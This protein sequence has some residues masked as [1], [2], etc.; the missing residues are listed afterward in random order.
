MARA[1]RNAV[2]GLALGW[3]AVCSH[4]GSRAAGLGAGW[5]GGRLVCCI[6]WI[7]GF[8]ACD[9]VCSC[10]SAQHQRAR[11]STGTTLWLGIG[12]VGAVYCHVGCSTAL[13]SGP[14]LVGIAGRDG[15]CHE[16]VWVGLARRARPYSLI[17]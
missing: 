6:W 9:R 3:P 16:D 2:V 17:V 13:G 4:R 12:E 1:P 10:G 14:E 11:G 8:V 5:A 7:D 15:R